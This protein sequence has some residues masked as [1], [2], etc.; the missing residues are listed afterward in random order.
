MSKKFCKFYL[1][2]FRPITKYEDQDVTRSRNMYRGMV[3][4]GALTLGFASYRFRRLKYAGMEAHEAPRDLNLPGSLINDLMMAVV[5]Y[6]G[7]HLL[8]C[9]YIYKHRQYIIER[10]N[11]EKQNNFN[12]D[13]FDLSQP[14]GNENKLLEEYPF[15]DLVSFS[16][17]QLHDM[18][19][20]A[21]EL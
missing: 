11:F 1:N 15:A 4:F 13:T 3:L 17:K 7:A 14:S 20:E 16:D 21:P 8:T 2:R 18:R 10:L 9:D 19:F 6:M 5:G 12:R